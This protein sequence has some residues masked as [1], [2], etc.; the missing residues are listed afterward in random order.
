MQKFDFKKATY[1]VSGLGQQTLDSALKLWKTKYPSY[2]HFRRA[3][4][5]V[6]ALKEFGSFVQEMWEDIIPLTVE[7]AFSEKNAETRRIYFDCL[8]VE[9]IFKA[10]K[11]VLLDRQVIK[12]KRHRWDDKNDPWLHEFE[13][14]YNL[15]SIDP[16]NLFA[17]SD[18]SKWQLERGATSKYIAVRCKCTSTQREYWIYVPEENTLTKGNIWDKK[19]EKKYDAIQAIAWTIRI[20]ITNPERIYRQGDIIVA[21]ESAESEVVK[22]YH[23]SKEQ[24]L[25]LMYSET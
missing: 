1:S 23:L 19:S 14:E 24:Y 8:G 3:V 4:I 20:D 18:M 13:D 11:P 15:Y 16:V 6:E 5:K 25:Q 2:E 22:A 12:K 17:T 21:K 9:R 7:E 10:A